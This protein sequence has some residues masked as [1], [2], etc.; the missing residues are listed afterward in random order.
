[1]QATD[2]AL[3]YTD[4]SKLMFP[5][6]RA[7]EMLGIHLR[8]IQA[9]D[10]DLGVE[11][12]RVPRG[13][14]MVRM[15]SLDDLFKIAR[16]RKEKG[17]VKPLAR[18]VT[19][20]TYIQKG[21]TGK[22][23]YAANLSIQFSLAGFKTLVIDNDP[24][25]DVSGIFGYD[26]DYTAEELLEVGIPADRAVDGHFC[27]LLQLPNSLHKTLG[28]VIKK[29]F[30]EYGPHLIPAEGSLEDMDSVLRNANGSDFR[31]MM[32]MEAARNGRV[33]GCDI[34]GYD[35]VIFDNAPTGSM[36][37]RNAMIAADILLCPIRMDKFSFRALSRLDFKLRE[38][39][40]DFS[41]MPEVV[42]IPSMFVRGR[43]RVQANLARVEAFFP[44][45][46]TSPIYMSEDY[47]KSLE[48]CIPLSLWSSANNM[49]QDA[50]REV[51]RELIA[52]IR[53]VAGGD[54]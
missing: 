49:T 37:S 19:L 33:N 28:E 6:Q 38:F 22:T 11:V 47:D 45:K 32:F 12:A 46:L 27:N 3:P 5:P 17:L 7:A 14:A 51:S 20:T 25:G 10:K 53:A 2:E 24:Q 26:P 13:N 41:R 48:H 42:A 50:M 29:P 40:R 23:T 1:M 21:G 52:R 8:T 36:L 44:G 31:Y 34:S 39:A 30:G 54:Q 4:Y 43:P 16:L 9:V 15:F 35:L 18:P